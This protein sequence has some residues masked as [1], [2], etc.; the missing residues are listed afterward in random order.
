M[1]Y[2][3]ITQHQNAYPI[4]LQCRVLGV[5]RNGYYHYEKNQANQP[6]DP[7]H[8]EMLEWGKD[9]AKSSGYTYGS[10]RM[11]RALNALGYPVSRSTARK[12]MR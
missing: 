11:K 3:F 5:S 9:I 12:L 10:R 4:T 2:S 6:D 1:K 7:S 8:Q